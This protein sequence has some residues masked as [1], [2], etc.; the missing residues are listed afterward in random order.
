MVL[1]SL[2]TDTFVWSPEAL[3]VTCTDMH[4]SKTPILIKITASS[5]HHGTSVLRIKVPQLI[6]SVFRLLPKDSP[7][8][9]YRRSENAS[10][11]PSTG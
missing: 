9:G 3:N 6:R 8:L 7:N 2:G 1:W 10:S 4:A 11:F 5:A